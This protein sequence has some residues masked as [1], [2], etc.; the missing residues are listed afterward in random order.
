MDS[1]QNCTLALIRIA[2]DQTCTPL[3]K[4]V[5]AIANSSYVTRHRFDVRF[6]MGV[7]SE[8]QT[9]AYG[10]HLAR[11]ISPPQSVNFVQTFWWLSFVFSD[12]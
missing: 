11:A 6:S 7:Y 1:D 5:A 3:H 12:S 9:D 4:N 8:A 2:R 10:R